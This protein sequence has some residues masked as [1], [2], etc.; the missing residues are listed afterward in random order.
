MTLDARMKKDIYDS[1]LF[2]YLFEK[3]PELIKLCKERVIPVQGDLIAE[4]LGME[5]AV[6]EMMKNEVEVII[7]SAASIDMNGSIHEMLQ[8]DYFG[9][10]RMLDFA[11]ECKNLRVFNHISTAYVNSNQK[12][13]SIISE[14]IHPNTGAEDFEV[15]INKILEKDLAALESE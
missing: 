13:W 15:Q 2:K 7:N 4:A 11:H 6:R 3:R 14:K 1:Q 8:I 10:K 9:P 12:P 5:P